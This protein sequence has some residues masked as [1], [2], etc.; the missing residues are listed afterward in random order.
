MGPSGAGKT[1]LL[2][3]LA[4]RNAGFGGEVRLNGEPWRESF[5]SVLAYMPQ[6]EMFLHELTPR[7][8]L[9]FMAQLRLHAM[10][11]AVQVCLRK[12]RNARTAEHRLLSNRVTG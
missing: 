10:P 1:S 9:G 2:N 12:K 4:Q 5:F 8:H 6:D 7:E 11:P 3:S